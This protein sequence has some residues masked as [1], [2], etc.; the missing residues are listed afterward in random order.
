MNDDT[1]YFSF[2]EKTL[3]KLI[4][5]STIATEIDLV[6]LLDAADLGGYIKE[7]N[8]SFQKQ[9][10]KSPLE[11][12]Q[13]SEGEQQLIAIR[14]GVELLRDRES[15][16][17]MDEPDT[18]LHPDW[19]R[20]FMNYLNSDNTKDHYIMATHSP[21]ALSMVHINNVVIM[22]NGVNHSANSESY[23]KDTNSILEEIL[24]IDKRPP[25]IREMET[26]YFDLISQDK[27][28]EAKKVRSEL[29]KNLN[30]SDPIFFKADAILKRKEF[31]SKK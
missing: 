14:G 8:I 7:I 2:N 20:E 26:K 17:L 13:L 25:H 22:Q 30:A 24:D 1:L 12:S 28:L 3:S 11:F 10:V 21:Q 9:K 5:S 15:L 31:L 27:L 23:G 19:Q 18:F 6:K 4:P 29:E 16:F